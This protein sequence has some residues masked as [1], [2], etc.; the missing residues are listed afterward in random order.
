MS[1]P[2]IALFAIVLL[3]VPQS[4]GSA[5]DWPGWM[6]ANRDGVYN[7]SG[8][9][10]EIPES[11][12]PVKWR[13]P[14]AGGYAGPAVA[15]GRVFVFD[16]VASSGD[17]VNDPNA[18]TALTG[19]ERLLV[20][21]ENTGKELWRYEYD[22]P[23]SISYPAGP[24]CTPT[25]D[26]GRV[27]LLGCEGD[28]NCLNAETG[29]LI[30]KRNFT[31]D[32]GAAVPLYGFCAHPLVDGDLVY[33]MV[34]GDGQG[35]VAFDKRSGEVRWKALDASGSYC[36]PSIIQSGGVS[37]LIVFHA[38]GVVS[39]DPSNGN[40]HWTVDL[41]PQYEMSVTRPMID[42]NLMY[43]SAI[44]SESVMLRLNTNRPA[45]RELWRGERDVSV[46]CSNST[47]LFVDGIVYGTDCHDGS[48]IAVQ[49][50]DGKRLW[51]T[52]QP[53]KPDEE[54]FVAH[55]TAFISRLG[56]SDKY[57]LFG[58]TG[59]LILATLTARGYQEHGRFQALEPTGDAFGRPVVWSHP[60]YANRTAYIR[61]DKEIVAIDLAKK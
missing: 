13:I 19:Q 17:A 14:I 30:W 33:C 48:L 1:I 58:E 37:Q 60:A 25:I 43:A 11:G 5:E 9:I 53:T 35:V 7:E 4:I 39:M 6:G 51:K 15:D 41:A 10:D 36:P 34:G 23:Y 54:R 56:N 18:R 3:L 32:L 8:V 45:V 44:G 20:L 24:R 31:T 55:G 27:Y 46:Y 40:V 49:A 59:H 28:L 29:E 2:Q 22:C 26:D 47:P 38:T 21:D 52:F 57:F 42:G 50:K 12:L 61:N 16:Y